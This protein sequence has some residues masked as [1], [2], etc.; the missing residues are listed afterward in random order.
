MDVA[1]IQTMVFSLLG[2]LGIFL[3]GMRHMSDGL[4]TVS[5]PSLRRL[6]ASVTQNRLM[7]TGVGVI[8]TTIVQSSSV[9]TVMTIG[10]VNSGIMDLTQALGVIVGAN[11]GTTVTGWILVLKVGAWGLPILGVAAF[12]FLFSKNEKRRYLALAIMGI[13][14]VFF[15]LEIMKGGVKVIRSIPEF[16]SA[17]AYFTATTYLGVLKCALAGCV[18]TIMVQSSSATLAITIALASQGVINFETAAALVLGE[19]IGTTITAY[20]AS[21]GASTSARRAAY[22]HVMFNVTGVF[23]ITALFRAYLP[24]VE[25]IVESM[26]GIDQ[27]TAPVVEN[28]ATVFPYV[29]TGIAVTHSV[30]NIVNTC[31]FLPFLPVIS[32]F[33]DRVVKDKAG[34]D[35]KMLTHLDYQHFESPIAA[36]ELS[37]HEI[38]KMATYSRDIYDELLVFIDDEGRRKE[39]TDHIFEQEEALDI[40]QK[41]ITEFLSDLM[42]EAISH[43][44]VEI[45]KNQ[46]RLTDEYET[47]SDYVASILK[48]HLGLKDHESSFDARQL[49]GIR[50]LHRKIGDYFDKINAY[51]LN[52][53]R[54]YNMSA[55]ESEGDLITDDIRKLRTAHWE[56]LATDKIDPIASTIYSDVL[57]SY[58]KVKDHLVNIAE[59]HAGL[60]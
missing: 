3:L 18:L 33:L 45:S 59:V 52:D 56:R 51:S 40:A 50:D 14:M 9:S 32:K 28:G 39:V 58:R 55:I 31:A 19:N 24:V 48:L 60:K 4:Q 11:I 25:W 17:F 35:D 53:E 49:D 6:I 54:I 27:I 43:E 2:G 37:G 36:L 34:T 8:V 57:Q 44:D 41:E 16:E 1:A 46:L 30:F 7:A 47:I 20:L 13:G 23:V 10:L 5:G 21:L 26:F 15:G 12:V 42:S 38:H 29:I 22:F